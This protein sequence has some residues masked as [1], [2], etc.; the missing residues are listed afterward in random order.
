MPS[1][2]A[3][4]AA[5]FSIY[6]ALFLLFRHDPV[7]HPDASSTPFWR[8][9]ALA[10]SSVFCAAAV[11]YSRIYLNYHTR[12]QVI[13]GC[14]AG[15]AY[16]LGWFLATTVARRVG[17]VDWFLDIP[18]VKWLRMRDLVVSESF[19]DAGWERYQQT[20]RRRTVDGARKRK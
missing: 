20:S 17:L 6:L 2:H 19:E 1:S 8:R 5:Y 10:A 14:A 11:A 13:A 9:L 7:N 16:A 12:G 3:Q 15:A 18:L 4:Y